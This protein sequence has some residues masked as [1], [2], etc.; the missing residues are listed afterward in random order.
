MKKILIV[1]D[2]LISAKLLSNLLKN[3]KYKIVKIVKT[4]E[5]AIELAQKSKVDLILMDIRLQGKIDGIEAMLEIRKFSKIPV[6]YI[7]GNSDS[8]TRKRA[9]ETSFSGYFTKPIDNKRTFICNKKNILKVYYNFKS[10]FALFFTCSNSNSNPFI[11]SNIE[12]VG[13]PG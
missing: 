10:L 1:E 9:K 7:T 12:S 13:L 5:E 4:G 3:E 6:I 8:P 11:L 2:E